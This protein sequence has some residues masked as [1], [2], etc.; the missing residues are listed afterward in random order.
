M[1][2]TKRG[3]RMG[4]LTFEDDTGSVDCTLYSEELEKYRNLLQEGEI[5]WVEGIVDY[6]NFTQGIRMSGKKI[7]SLAEA[8]ETQGKAL[9]IKIS[10]QTAEAACQESFKKILQ[11]YPGN[12]PVY[13]QYGNGDAS[14]KCQ[15]GH[16]WRVKPNDAL[17]QRLGYL[18]SAENIEVW[19]QA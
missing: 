18:F 7:A 10:A 6:D 11:E 8:R 13:L 1:V 15:L 3:D 12:F 17:M 14:V 16:Q 5:L 2:M 4:I 19:Y 9:I